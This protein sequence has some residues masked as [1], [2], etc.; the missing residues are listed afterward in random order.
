[1]FLS[2]GQSDAKLPVLSSQLNKLRNA[3]VNKQRSMTTKDVHF[4][5]DNA[6]AKSSRDNVHQIYIKSFKNA[7]KEEADNL[8][9]EDE[10]VLAVGLRNKI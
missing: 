7:G 10:N 8:G 4:H 2:G 5:I 1:M 3:G 6:M 9:I